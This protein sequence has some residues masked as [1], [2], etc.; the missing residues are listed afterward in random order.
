MI[1]TEY[2]NNGTLIKHFSDSE[3]ML[4]QLETGIK[5]SSAIDLVPCKYT[6]IE[7][8]EKIISRPPVDE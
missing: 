5:F 1:I 8:N 7:T 2:L 4:E 3:F 6:Y